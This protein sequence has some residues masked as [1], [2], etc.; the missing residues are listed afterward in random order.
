MAGVLSTVCADPSQVSPDVVEQHVE[1]AR[2]R[3]G[4]TE[5]DREFTLASRRWY[6]R[7]PT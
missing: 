7:P 1:V 3:F 6:P 2:R 5:A 4:F